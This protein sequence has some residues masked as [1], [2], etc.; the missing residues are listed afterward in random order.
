MSLAR[1]V[2]GEEK[3][4]PPAEAALPGGGRG[5]PVLNFGGLNPKLKP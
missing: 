1:R 3:P 4:A 2:L 5:G